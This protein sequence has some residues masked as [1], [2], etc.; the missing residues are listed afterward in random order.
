MVIVLITIAYYTEDNQNVKEEEKSSK[1]T[2]EFLS[3]SW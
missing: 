1:N 2:Q 3:S